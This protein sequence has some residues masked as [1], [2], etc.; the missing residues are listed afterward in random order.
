MWVEENGHGGG[1]FRKRERCMQMP[2]TGKHP[3]PGSANQGWKDWLSLGCEILRQ[4]GKLGKQRQSPEQ[5]NPKPESPIKSSNQKLNVRC[6]LFAQGG[7][8]GEFTG[9]VESTDGS[10]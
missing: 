4:W 1:H 6:L 10:L 8:Q 9:L 7:C 5:F 2:G 3:C